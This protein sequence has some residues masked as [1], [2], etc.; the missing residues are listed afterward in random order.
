MM[1][2]EYQ[3]AEAKPLLKQNN[4]FVK[5]HQF[6]KVNKKK[7]KK[8]QTTAISIYPVPYSSMQTHTRMIGKENEHQRTDRS[9]D[10]RR[11]ERVAC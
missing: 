9:R 2:I 11:V 1:Q 3:F 6:K 8:K 10:E 5:N 4:L 7:K